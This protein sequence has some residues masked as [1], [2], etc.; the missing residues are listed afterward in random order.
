M[1]SDS[2][3]FAIANRLFAPAVLFVLAFLSQPVLSPGQ[4]LQVV[5]QFKNEKVFWRQFEIAKEIVKRH[6]ASV[7]SSL[8]DWLNHE[9]R[10]IRGNAARQIRARTNR[11]ATDMQRAPRAYGIDALLL[12]LRARLREIMMHTPLRPPHTQ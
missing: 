6:D 7:L 8:V 11:F 5:D 9:D 10:P 3:A 1:K 2:V 4:S 12:A